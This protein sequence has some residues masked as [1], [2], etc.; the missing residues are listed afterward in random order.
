M[1]AADLFGGPPDRSDLASPLV[2]TDEPPK[3]AAYLFGGE[4]ENAIPGSLQSKVLPVQDM[5]DDLFGDSGG[6]GGNGGGRGSDGDMGGFGAPPVVPRSS[7]FTPSSN[8]Q[9]VPDSL[10]GEPVVT[11]STEE[12]FDFGPPSEPAG[13][14][15]T[16][17]GY[18]G[19][20]MHAESFLPPV[21]STSGRSPPP[22]SND[23]LGPPPPPR[24]D[25]AINVSTEETHP[26]GA[27]ANLDAPPNDIFGEP[28]SETVQWWGTSP[29]V[30]QLFSSTPSTE[31]VP[32]IDQ[33]QT[34]PDASA[35]PSVQDR[36]VSPP[37]GDI[38]RV[39][40]SRF[41]VSSSLPPS[42][43]SSPPTDNVFGAPPLGAPTGA[44]PV[45]FSG[46]SP[47]SSSLPNTGNPFRTERP[48]VKALDSPPPPPAQTIDTAPRIVS[49]GAT[50]TALSWTTNR[51][52]PPHWTTQHQQPAHAKSP[53]VGDEP[54]GNSMRSRVSSPAA[55]PLTV[56]SSRCA[57]EP[58]SV[59]IVPM[60]KGFAGLSQ[61]PAKAGGGGSSSGEPFG[62]SS[63]VMGDASRGNPFGSSLGP[64]VASQANDIFGSSS[65]GND[66]FGC[67]E[68]T[69]VDRTSPLPPFQAPEALKGEGQPSPHSDFTATV[70]GDHQ[71]AWST[72]QDGVSGFGAPPGAPPRDVFDFEAEEEDDGSTPW[73]Q[74]SMHKVDQVGTNEESSSVPYGNN[75]GDGV[76]EVATDR[77]IFDAP[78][79][80]SAWSVTHALHTTAEVATQNESAEFEASSSAVF[81]APA[82]DSVSA[83]E[84][85][86]MQD[87]ATLVSGGQQQ[88]PPQL[89]HEEPDKGSI[90]PVAPISL[91]SHSTLGV[92]RDAPTVAGEE[93]NPVDAEA[94]PVL[95][96]QEEVSKGRES[97]GWDNQSLVPLQ[98]DIYGAPPGEL[99]TGTND[100]PFEAP[101]DGGGGFED[102]GMCPAVPAPVSGPETSSGV[103]EACETRVVSAPETL[104]ADGRNDDRNTFERKLDSSEVMAPKEEEIGK[105]AMT[106]NP[107]E[108][109]T[110]EH[111]DE[112]VKHPLLGH[113]DGARPDIM[114]TPAALTNARSSFRGYYIS[115]ASPLGP[116]P[117]PSSPRRLFASR[118]ASWAVRETTPESDS[119]FCEVF[120]N[121]AARCGGPP[122]RELATIHDMERVESDEPAPTLAMSAVAAP[123]L[124]VLASPSESGVG[125]TAEESSSAV[126]PSSLIV[127]SQQEAE[128]GS[129]IDQANS[130]TSPAGVWD[131][132]SETHAVEAQGFL[133]G[134]GSAMSG[135]PASVPPPVAVQPHSSGAAEVAMDDVKDEKNT[136]ACNKEEEQYPSSVTTSRTGTAVEH[137]A[138]AGRTVNVDGDWNTGDDWS[139]GS[140]NRCSSGVSVDSAKD[141][142]KT[143]GGRLEA[144]KEDSD[145]PERT[146]GVLGEGGPRNHPEDDRD[147]S[148]GDCEGDNNRSLREEEMIEVRA[149]GKTEE[150]DDMDDSFEIS[151]EEND[152]VVS[153]VERTAA[154]FFSVRRGK[155]QICP[156]PLVIVIPLVGIFR[157][158]M[159]RQSYVI[160]VE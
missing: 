145:E 14:A 99:F 82:T 118:S 28:S 60:D 132:Y 100:D 64:G 156:P 134:V 108:Q 151:D 4:A 11:R 77:G 80:N 35:M 53:Q 52:V 44:P 123:N 67:E 114:E 61:G 113:R 126:E 72:E 71:P 103:A 112:E 41:S 107:E 58:L 140:D 104:T 147:E 76:S 129:D 65:G 7:G 23:A 130:L 75:T 90:S 22:S 88:V 120:S 121:K 62:P 39:S 42:R 159:L 49:D 51:S 55:G 34:R 150:E 70:A 30:E 24:G 93:H 19:G 124:T 73:W 9:G 131:G 101:G 149:V 155:T 89:I 63:G 116:S 27:A 20:N 33:A 142:N 37:P 157:S 8:L 110:E 32:I 111:R 128:S 137:N 56:E 29:P 83:V 15:M 94:N 154:D 117:A 144:R 138:D 36:L 26:H 105:Q 98:P 119:D 68:G 127:D 21:D 78:T 48:R 10:F 50:T 47:P 95:R 79:D 133:L 13:Y 57:S 148:G 54:H 143:E 69:D 97:H 139:E 2:A 16:P 18:D 43:P 40:S 153:A 74:T 96:Q 91:E 3:S 122:L 86:P 59:E 135:H 109:A 125:E 136:Q 87:H 160:V 158:W 141:S 1:N 17:G 146:S 31:S 6:G 45:I 5:P 84:A 38:A 12:A 115:T 85:K 25:N 66:I 102:W 46:A 81:G 106:V 92:G 152:N